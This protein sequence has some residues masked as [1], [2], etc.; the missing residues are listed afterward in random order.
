M[1]PTP[2]I[3]VT[4]ATG[5]IANLLI[6]QLLARGY[7]VRAL[8]RKPER[9]NARKWFPQ[10]EMIRGDVMNPS[11]LAPALDGVHTAYYL[12]HNM[13]AGHGYTSLE[14][15]SARNFAQAA[16]SAGVQHIVYLGG[17]A[18]SEQDIAPHMR[19]RIETGA[20]LRQ[21]KVPV[22][23][24][25]AGVI[26]GSGSISFEMIRFMTELF[27][28]IPAPTWLKNKS[29]PIATQ[30]IIDYLLAALETNDRQGKVF[31][32]GGPQVFSYQELMLRYAKIRGHKRSFILLPFIPAW[33]M[34]FGIGLATPVPPAIASALMAGLSRDSVVI[35]N[36]ARKTFPEVMLIDF[37]SAVREA[38]RRLHP[39]EI[40]HVWEDGQGDVKNLK[41]EGFFIHHREMKINLPI[42]AP[43]LSYKKFSFGEEWIQWRVSRVGNP[44]YLKQTAYF[45]PRGLGGFLYW[46]LFYPFHIFRFRRLI[47]NIGGKIKIK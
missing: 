39:L 29:Q 36:D 9:L 7:R 10:V 16:E 27:P 44:T 14:I 2:L 21:G 17:L 38:M 45:A 26:I 32:I 8:A 11:T 40:E 18:D 37:E 25:R 13:A 5:Y 3:L 31:E 43:P 19:S 28:I 46:Y 1:N 42:E 22:T 15:E 34:A 35:H 12:V 33:F 6:P 47:K 24:F 23:E 41:H 20:S 4:G 30:N